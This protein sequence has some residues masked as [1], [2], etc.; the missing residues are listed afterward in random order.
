MPDDI[1]LIP[2]HVN[3]RKGAKGRPRRIGMHLPGKRK[4]C[5]IL[6]KKAA[7]DMQVATFL[8]KHGLEEN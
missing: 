8:E 2:L 7:T 1:V 4:A 6:D 5:L 3:N